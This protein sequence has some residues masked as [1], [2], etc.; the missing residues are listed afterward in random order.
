MQ[1]HFPDIHI[2]FGYMHAYILDAIAKYHLY[3][4]REGKEAL[5]MAL[6]IGR[7][8]NVILPFAEYGG[9]IVDMLSDW[10]RTDNGDEYLN[11]VFDHVIIYKKNL[12]NFLVKNLKKGLLTEREEEIAKLLVDGY[13]NRDIAE[14]L[15]IAE[16]TVKKTITSIYRKLGV[17]SRAAAVRKVIDAKMI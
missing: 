5:K 12:D 2:Q 10:V 17:S 16:I 14:K 15:Y 7:D 8:D 9:Y 13:H 3:G 1:Q 6:D 4:L 11:R